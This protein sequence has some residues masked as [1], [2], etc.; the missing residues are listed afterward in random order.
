M[1]AAFL[2][3]ASAADG[4]VVASITTLRD[5]V[6]ALDDPKGTII[7]FNAL[8]TPEWVAYTDGDEVAP[9]KTIEVEA[10]EVILVQVN[11]ASTLQLADAADLAGTGWT[12]FDLFGGVVLEDPA[13]YDTATGVVPAYAWEVPA[14]AEVDDEF[15]G[16]LLA[17]EA[18]ADVFAFVL[19][20]TVVKKGG[21]PWIWIFLILLILGGVAA[22]LY[23]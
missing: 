5:E 23:V 15:R 21:F 19:K 12:A 9:T 6:T 10:G 18:D 8:S 11:V 7:E 3:A 16:G 14:T 20:A 17:T 2:A 13:D 22:Y 1:G 4:E